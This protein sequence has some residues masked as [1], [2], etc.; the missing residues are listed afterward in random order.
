MCHELLARRSEV[1]AD[2]DRTDGDAWLRIDEAARKLV[3]RAQRAKWSKW[4]SDVRNHAASSGSAAKTSA[5]V[6]WLT[7]GKGSDGQNRRR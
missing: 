5:N 3:E 7:K 2:G 4:L 6:R 1:L